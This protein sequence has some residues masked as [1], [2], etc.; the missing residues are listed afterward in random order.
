MGGPLPD[1]RFFA[2][3]PDKRISRSV[4]RPTRWLQSYGANAM[5]YFGRIFHQQGRKIM[6]AIDI[7]QIPP[8]WPLPAVTPLERCSIPLSN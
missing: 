1:R 5:V 8:E 2:P 7:R 6:Q 4:Y 3:W